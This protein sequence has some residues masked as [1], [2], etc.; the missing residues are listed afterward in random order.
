M[1]AQAT[2]SER[3]TPL[4]HLREWL[5]VTRVDTTR[6]VVVDS[7]NIV[8]D[9]PDRVFTSV[10]YFRTVQEFTDQLAAPVLPRSQS[11]APGNTDSNRHFFDPGRTCRSRFST[12]CHRRRADPTDRRQ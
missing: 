5:E 6:R 7:H 2:M 3:E 12:R 8:G 9:G 10:L 11:A 1:D 4:G